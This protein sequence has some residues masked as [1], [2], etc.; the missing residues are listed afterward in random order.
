MEAPGRFSRVDGRQP[1]MLAAHVMHYASPLA[2]GEK[3]DGE[4]NGKI[5]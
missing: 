4:R 2:L 1:L 5:K 3:N